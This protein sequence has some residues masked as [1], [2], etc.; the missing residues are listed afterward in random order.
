MCASGNL[1]LVANGSGSAV[2]CT[3]DIPCTADCST[4]GKNY[5]I[6]GGGC[7]C[8]NR[9]SAIAQSTLVGSDLDVN[10]LLNAPSTKPTTQ[11]CACNIGMGGGGGGGGG[12]HGE[13]PNEPAGSSDDENKEDTTVLPGFAVAYCCDTSTKWWQL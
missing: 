8:P 11:Y 1:V 7:N 13:D 4:L 10:G 12:D 2:N 6:I 9:P 3:R 5:V